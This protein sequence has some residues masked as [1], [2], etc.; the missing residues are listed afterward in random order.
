MFAA[1]TRHKSRLL[2]N[3]AHRLREGQGGASPIQFKLKNLECVE[4]TC[5][6]YGSLPDVLELQVGQGFTRRPSDSWDPEELKT[7]PSQLRPVHGETLDL[8]LRQKAYLLQS[9]RG[10][11]ANVDSHMLAYFASEE[12]SRI[13]H[14]GL[15][16]PV[17]VL[18]LGAGNG[19][20]SILFARAHQMSNVHMIELQPQLAER[21]GRNIALN[22]ID[23]KVTQFDLK[24]GRLPDGISGCFDIVLIN[25]PFYR[26][27]SR[28]APKVK[29]KYL[30]HQES[31]ATIDHFL[32]AARTACDHLNPDA[33]IAIIHDID[34][35]ARVKKAV[36]D[37]NLKI[38]QSREIVHTVQEKPSRILLKLEHR[39]KQ[40]RHSTTRGVNDQECSTGLSDINTEFSPS[41]PPLVLHPSIQSQRVY[42]EEI[43]RFLEALPIPTLRIGRLRET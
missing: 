7:L 21:A 28:K 13:S 16:K 20:V 30:A 34:E 1:S 41:L 29:E 8:I 42:T 12:Y 6:C 25:P 40:N 32:R 9:R 11:R 24:D 38:C 19:L 3:L 31:S 14:N 15:P 18:D 36:L 37:A 35:L 43:E 33:F 4:K 5:R 22:D 26:G 27:G 23:G 10:Y 17:R 39:A 2:L